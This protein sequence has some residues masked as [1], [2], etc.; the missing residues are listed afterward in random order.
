MYNVGYFDQTDEDFIAHVNTILDQCTLNKEVWMLDPERLSTLTYLTTS[1]NTA[2][3]ANIDKAKR[4]LL[5]SAHKKAA[6]G[7]LKPFLSLFVSYLEITSS[8]PDEALESMSLRPRHHHKSEPIPPPEEEPV[9]TTVRRHGEITAYVSREEL[10]HP[11]ES[12][13]RPKYHGFKLR[14]RFVGETEYHIELSTRLHYTI[15]FEREDATKRVEL[16]AAWINPRLQEGPWS[17]TITEVIE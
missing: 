10:G 1:A 5:T 8:V 2:Y 11:T 13:T 12:V 3:K 6:F 7:E 16:E 15:F 14:W 9:L 17:D 4:N